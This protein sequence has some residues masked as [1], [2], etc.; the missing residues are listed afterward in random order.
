LWSHVARRAALI[1]A[2]SG[3]EGSRQEYVSETRLIIGRA[4]ERE[5][6]IRDEGVL[7]KGVAATSDAKRFY[8]KAHRTPRET[9][10]RKGKKLRE[11]GGKAY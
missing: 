3:T 6:S 9:G 8:K 5:S 2:L 7:E 4:Q 11:R 10:V 1:F